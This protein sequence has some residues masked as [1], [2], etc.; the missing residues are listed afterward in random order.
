MRGNKQGFSR[1]GNYPDRFENDSKAAWFDTLLHDAGASVKMVF[2]FVGRK[3]VS[4]SSSSL[5]ECNELKK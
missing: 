5:Y 1:Q 3:T 4:F 2:V